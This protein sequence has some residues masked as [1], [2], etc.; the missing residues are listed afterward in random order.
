MFKQVLAT[1]ALLASTLGAYTNET[2]SAPAGNGTVVTT[3]ITV[4]DYTTYCPASTVVTITKCDQECYPTA[5]T[6]TEATTLTVTGECVVPTTYT[7][8]PAEPAPETPTPETPAP[9]TPAPAEESTVAGPSTV[10]EQSTVAAESTAVPVSSFEAGANK[11][12]VGAFAGLA[13]V[14]AALI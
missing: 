8:T 5:I 14:A 12:A 9:E 13:A 11:A 7:S 4:T 1:S 10:A 6:V 2:S 3:D